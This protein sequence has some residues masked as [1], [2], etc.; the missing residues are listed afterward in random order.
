MLV[1]HLNNCFKIRPL[2]LLIFQ[3]VEQPFYIY[4]IRAVCLA[5]GELFIVLT[6]STYKCLISYF[7]NRYPAIE[8]IFF[9]GSQI[10]ISTDSYA[11]PYCR[12]S[13]CY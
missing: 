12:C 4:S 2:P 8:Y 7:I 11:Y 5:I 1:N 10:P 13:L 6:H 9:P 3:I